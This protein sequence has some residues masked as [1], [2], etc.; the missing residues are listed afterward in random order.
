LQALLA[1]HVP[2]ADVLV[3]AAA[4]ADFR[5]KVDLKNFNGKF[6]RSDQSLHLELEPTPDLLA[7]VAATKRA[8]QLM[9]GFALEP[10][11]ELIASAIAKLERK[12]V[13]LVVGNPLETMDS[14]TIEATVFSRD[15]SQLHTAGAIEKPVFALWLLDIIEHAYT[16]L[17]PAPT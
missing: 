2:N 7:Q 16:T 11:A 9:V 4:V 15:G 14:P 12:R 3:M 5:P 17:L 13:D 8:N 10:R 6:R 1:E